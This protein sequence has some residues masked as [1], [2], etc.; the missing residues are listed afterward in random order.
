MRSMS[1]QGP[2]ERC[3]RCPAPAPHHHCAEYRLTKTQQ[4]LDPPAVGFEQAIANLTPGSWP[5]D[6]IE[7]AHETTRVSEVLQDVSR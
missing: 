7:L 3:L 6:A 2:V 1:A 5:E 4:G